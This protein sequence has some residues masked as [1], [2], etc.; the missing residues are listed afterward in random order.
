VKTNVTAKPVIFLH[1]TNYS[2][3]VVCYTCSC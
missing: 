2:Y 3:A 1:E